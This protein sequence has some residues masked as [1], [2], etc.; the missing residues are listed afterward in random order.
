MPEASRVNLGEPTTL[1]ITPRLSQNSLSRQ[2]L[3][4]DTTFANKIL[5]FISLISNNLK[6]N[7]FFMVDGV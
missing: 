2:W 5:F 4:H 6:A 1:S 7:F 3:N